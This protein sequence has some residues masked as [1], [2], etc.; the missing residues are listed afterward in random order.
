MYSHP[1]IIESQR[2]IFTDSRPASCGFAFCLG[3]LSVGA[4]ALLWLLVL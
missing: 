3:A 2:R 1:T 4:A